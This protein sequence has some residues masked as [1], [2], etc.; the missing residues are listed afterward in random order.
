MLKNSVTY[1]GEIKAWPF[2]SIP[3]YPLSFLPKA[4]ISPVSLLS[5]VW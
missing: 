4:Y 5:K 1:L 3:S 2:V